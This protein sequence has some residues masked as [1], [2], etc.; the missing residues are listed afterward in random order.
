MI[1]SVDRPGHVPAL[2]FA[3]DEVIIDLDDCEVRVRAEMS[4]Q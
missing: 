1:G 4:K 3:L 2:A